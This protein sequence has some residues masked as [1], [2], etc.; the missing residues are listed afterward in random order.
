MRR[1]VL[2]SLFIA[3][4]LFAAGAAWFALGRPGL[5]STGQ[6]AGGAS[7]TRALPPFRRIVVEGLADVTLVEGDSESLAVVGGTRA[8]TV[9]ATVRDDVLLLAAGESRRWWQW[10]GGGSTKTPRLTITF[11]T[12]D[13][14]QLSGAV[15]LRA[16]RVK[17]A[18]LDIAAAGAATIRIDDLDTDRLKLSGSG[19]IKA[20]FAGRAREQTIALSGAGAFRG[21]GL[22][23]ERA[24]VTVSGAGKAL[25]NATQ[26]LAVSISGA[27]NVEY[28]GDPK[29]TQ[30]ISGAGKIRRRNA[31]G[32]AWSNLAARDAESGFLPPEQQARG[33]ITARASARRPVSYPA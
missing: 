14:L 6:Q 33:A 15:K 13:S 4:V 31:D 10:L 9:S 17:T 3:A 5:A 28:L 18:S 23:G 7:E 1:I 20:E 11:R 2:V 24:K 22:A 21:A 27:G 8:G 32:G 19:A 16:A 26:T 12:L 30:E 25:V 29:I